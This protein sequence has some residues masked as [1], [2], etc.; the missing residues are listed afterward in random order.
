[1]QIRLQLRGTNTLSCVTT[2][3][4]IVFVILGKKSFFCVFFVF[5]FFFFPFR[6]DLFSEEEWHAIKY[7]KNFPLVE[8]AKSLPTESILFF[9]QKC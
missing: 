8:T 4:N 6:M 9:R 5:V 1:M 3:I 7:K 2:P